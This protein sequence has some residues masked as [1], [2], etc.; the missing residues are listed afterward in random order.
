MKE[1]CFIVIFMLSIFF[2]GAV[3]SGDY[4]NLT[5][6]DRIM[7]SVSYYEV[8][9]KYK[10][11]GKE[12]EYKSH[13]SEAFKIE[14]DV[15]KYYNG[16]YPIPVKKIEFDWDNIFIEEDE[17]ETPETDTGK[18]STEEVRISEDTDTTDDHT[19]TEDSSDSRISKEN[20]NKETTE[21]ISTIDLMK[22]SWMGFL[23]SIIKSDYETA[24]LYFN[25]TLVLEEED[26]IVTRDEV[27]ESI[28]GWKDSNDSNIPEYRLNF[29][30]IDDTKGVIEITFND[31]FDFFLPV[32]NNQLS[33]EC[34]IEDDKAL[35]NKILS[36]NEK[37]VEADISDDAKVLV[38]GFITKLIEGD[39]DN[40]LSVFNQ[41]VWFN[42]LN[43]LLTQEMLRENFEQWKKL[44]SH[45]TES[46][47]LLSDYLKIDTDDD[48][49]IIDEWNFESNDF[50]Q[51]RAVFSDMPPVPGNSN[52]S[53]YLFIVENI[54]KANDLYK[55]VAVGQL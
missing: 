38:S 49:G 6:R 20:D 26:I 27:K 14:K 53:T 16:E 8:A 43:M 1:K 54:D 52:K 50:Y 25:D 36:I 35:F 10:D 2:I 21:V 31:E 45:I 3:D 40:A 51:V 23:T 13:L 41:D 11:L 46:S 37:S 5:D 33:I 12:K 34:L 7:L 47:Q 24:S 15:E 9:L 44:N 55:I 48:L 19:I 4:D 30:E 39:I 32:T 28:I 42:E 29:I 18:D 22:R 17:E